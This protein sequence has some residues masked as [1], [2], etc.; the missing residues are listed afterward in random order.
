MHLSDMNR[1]DILEKSEYFLWSDG[2]LAYSTW[3][4]E[5]CLARRLNFKA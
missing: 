4:A 3:E 5:V 2:S 1:E